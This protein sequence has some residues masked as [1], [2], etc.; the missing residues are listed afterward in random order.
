MNSCF[1]RREIRSDIEELAVLWGKY[2]ING[3]VRLNIPPGM[4]QDLLFSYK[5]GK[6]SV[7]K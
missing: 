5:M 4:E 6:S 1:H 2:Y 7:C 3:Y